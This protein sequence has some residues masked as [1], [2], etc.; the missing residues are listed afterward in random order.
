MTSTYC[1]IL[2]N[3]VVCCAFVHVLFPNLPSLA[4]FSYVAVSGVPEPSNDHAICMIRF[5][6]DM[7]SIFKEVQS[8]L[9]FRLQTQNLGMRIGIHSGPVTVSH[10]KSFGSLSNWLANSFLDLLHLFECFGFLSLT[11]LPCRS[12]SCLYVVTISKQ[13]GVLRGEKARFQLFGDTVNTTARHESNGKPGRIHISK[14]TAEILQEAGLE[15]WYR[16]RTHKIHAKGK[17]ELET[18]WINI[19]DDMSSLGMSTDMAGNV[20][21]ILEWPGDAV[22]GLSEYVFCSR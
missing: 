6:K 11:Q 3:H 12:L 20:T 2:A 22:A 21:S 17:G 13:A 18:F 7:L 14:Q 1:R 4:P 15:S 16:P 5:A 9:S 10:H 8:E 19:E